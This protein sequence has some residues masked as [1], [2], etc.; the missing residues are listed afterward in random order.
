M[1]DKAFAEYFNIQKLAAG[2]LLYSA[3]AEESLRKGYAE[4]GIKGFWKARLAFLEKRSHDDLAVAEYCARLGEKDR[5]LT[6][7]EKAYGRHNF[8][9]ALIQVDPVFSDIST[10]ARFER[11]SDRIF[12]KN[13]RKRS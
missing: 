1:Y 3:A 10:D 11:L 4:G 13:E 12:P 9:L 2:N 5:A 6:L 7:L 8:G